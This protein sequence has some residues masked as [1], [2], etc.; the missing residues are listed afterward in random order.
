MDTVG[1][2]GLRQA[3]LDPESRI[4]YTGPKERRRGARIPAASWEG[5]VLDGVSFPLNA[6]LNCLIG[7]RGAGKV[8]GHRDHQIRA[9]SRLSPPGFEATAG[10]VLK[11]LP[12]GL[13]GFAADRDG[14]AE[15]E[16][17][18]RAYGAH[19]PIVRKHGG[20]HVPISMQRNLIRL[21]VLGQKEIFGVAQNETARLEMLDAVAAEE[22]REVVSR[23]AELVARCEENATLVACLSRQIDDSQTRLAELPAMEG[24]R[25]HFREAGFDELLEERR[26]P[27]R[28]G[29]PRGT[30][31]PPARRRHH[32]ELVGER[33]P[34]GQPRPVET[35]PRV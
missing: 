27:D 13:D 14:R 29:P 22:L 23:E 34:A 28:E 2:T 30:A 32:R 10:E 25:A 7:G 12:V 33:E 26:Q 11:G 18:D 5:G 16:V 24:W 20:T 1:V 17:R 31:R 4:A 9:W 15:T 21:R 19:A 6:E 3:F 8:D 35:P